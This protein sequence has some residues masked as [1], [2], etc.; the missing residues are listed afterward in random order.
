[1]GCAAR[2]VLWAHGMRPDEGKT[3]EKQKKS[4]GKMGD[5]LAAIPR[6]GDSVCSFFALNVCSRFRVLCSDSRTQTAR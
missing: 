2:P 5:D 3:K 4:E 1:M 6:A